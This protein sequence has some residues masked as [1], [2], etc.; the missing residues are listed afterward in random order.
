MEP[1]I[2]IECLTAKAVPPPPNDASVA[3]GIR[4]VSNAVRTRSALPPMVKGPLPA[5]VA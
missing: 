1:R 5:F 2:R 4:R 3:A